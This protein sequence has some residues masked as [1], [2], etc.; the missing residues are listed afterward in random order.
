MENF[1]EI[2]NLKKKIQLRANTRE[3]ADM[4]IC[5]GSM[6]IFTYL[7]A[8]AEYFILFI[9]FSIAKVYLIW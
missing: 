4:W 2:E 1:Y 6:H 7:R 3:R 5:I 9:P 8:V